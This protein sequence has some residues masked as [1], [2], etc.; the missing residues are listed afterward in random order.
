MALITEDQIA[1]AG[2]DTDIAAR[3]LTGGGTW[4]TRISTSTQVINITDATPDYF[5]GSS[6]SAT[7]IYKTSVSAPDLN[8][9]A[10]LESHWTSFTQNSNGPMLACSGTSAGSREWYGFY[11][12]G[13]APHDYF[14]NKYDQ[15]GGIDVNVGVSQATAGVSLSTGVTYNQ[16][17]R[18]IDNGDGTVT[19]KGY[20][21]DVEVV[22]YTDD[23]TTD[24]PIHGAGVGG[25]RMRAGG[26][27]FS[28]VHQTWGGTAVPIFVHH[29][30]QQ[31]MA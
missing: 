28:F 6:T 8:D 2:A 19:I 24:G 7:S 1:S 17:I 10:I 23:G 16:K 30:K 25:M 9:E 21:D 13:T 22:S 4:A 3:T 14:I 5:V 11:V 31:G 27:A 20:I 29:M 26:R 15:A 18:R 12:G